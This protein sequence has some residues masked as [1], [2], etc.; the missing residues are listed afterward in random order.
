M[1]ATS[2]RLPYEHQDSLWKHMATECS[3][4]LLSPE[5][6]K[7]R[8]TN[9]A[10]ILDRVN[11]GGY[12]PAKPLGFL[13]APKQNSVA[14][15]VPV[16]THTDAAVYCACLKTVDNALAAKAVPNTFGGWRLD[17]AR[18]T[19]EEKAALELFNGED[20]QS[21]PLSCFNRGAWVK[22]WNQFWKLL[23]AQYEHAAETCCFAMFDVAN[24]YDSVD[25]RR[26]ENGVRSESQ[27]A[28]FAMN[29]LFHLLRT[30]NKAHCLYRDSTKGFR[31]L[32]IE[33]DH[34]CPKSVAPTV[35]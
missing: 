14:R 16:L 7:A 8:K 22:Q 4:P 17:G 6:Y 12:S 11:D 3:V 33:C 5:E 31:A 1:A 15:F 20:S 21:I 2:T 23:A 18:R 9:L 24:F 28:H 10:A 25:L 19:M 35:P 30:W 27:G 13:S 29:V 26:L 32:K 34:W